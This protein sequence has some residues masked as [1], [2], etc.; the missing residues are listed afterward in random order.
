MKK[1]SEE[2][3]LVQFLLY[4]MWVIYKGYME[5]EGRLMV[6]QSWGFEELQSLHWH[7]E[8]CEDENVKLDHNNGH[9]TP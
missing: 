9:T 2:C 5:I 7:M 6:Y 4:K 1:S 8:F 3:L